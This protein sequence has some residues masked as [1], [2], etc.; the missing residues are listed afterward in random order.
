[1]TTVDHSYHIALRSGLGSLC[2]PVFHDRVWRGVANN[3]AERV[4]P[5]NGGDT[6]IS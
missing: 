4:L 5:G 2:T 3:C 1:M 6:M